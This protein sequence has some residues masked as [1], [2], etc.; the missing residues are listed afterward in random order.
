VDCQNLEKFTAM[1][2]LWVDIEWESDTPNIVN[3]QL[4]TVISN[5]PGSL[6]AVTTTI[7]DH[8]GNITNIQLTSRTLEFFTFVTDVEVSDVRHLRSIVAALQSNPFIESV[9]RAKS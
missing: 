8:G 2:E 3:A 4:E 5:E 1:P 6:A 7:S 9:E